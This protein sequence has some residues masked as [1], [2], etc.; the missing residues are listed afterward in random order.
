MPMLRI[1]ETLEEGERPG[2]PLGDR[3]QALAF[4]GRWLSPAV[5]APVL[6]AP[7]A[8]R[9]RRR[10]R[11]LN[12]LT[13]VLLCVAMHL[14]RRE[15]LSWVFRELVS[16]V[17]WLRPL[18]DTRI[19]RGGVSRA[20]YRLGA[21]PLIALFRRLCHPLATVETPGAFGF[22][23]RLM[24][25]DSTVFDL[26]DTEANEARFG[27]PEHQH[28]PGA[29]PQAQLVALCECGTHAICDAKVAH[30]LA[31]PRA[32]ARRLLRS[33]TAEMLVMLDQ[34]F[35]GYDLFAAL[36][37]RDAH[38][39][40]RVLPHVRPTVTRTL[41]DGTQLVR[42]AKRAERHQ[43]T[44]ERLA[45]RLIRSTIDDPGRPGH[46]VERRLLTSLLDPATAPALDLIVAYHERWEEEL[47]IDELATHQLAAIP[48]RSK[49]PVGVY[50]ELYA[51]LLAQY[52]VRSLMAEAAAAA[53]TP[54]DPRQL[55]FVGAVRLLREALPDF[56]RYAPAAHPTITA[57]LLAEIAATVLPPRA[58]RSNPRVV[59]QRCSP[60]PAKRRRHRHWPQPTKPFAHAVV[61]R[62]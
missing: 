37:K 21:A 19:T 35:Y 39:L 58:N 23:R 27:R 16:G 7:R 4:L 53:P 28:T 44:G 59:K 1:R 54:L 51:L 52:L 43:R 50:Q 33:V 46:G 12:A 41:P 2:G 14:W 57:R 15:E 5:L 32:L 56:Q 62:S 38:V 13:T 42:I 34:G 31:D 55:S 36:R 8:S 20:R 6:P 45:L 48:L 25:I 61:L 11:Q 60:F 29:W 24:A 26:A 49:R 22:G 40:A 3:Y 18:A 17:R 30:H 9:L 47:A 10:D